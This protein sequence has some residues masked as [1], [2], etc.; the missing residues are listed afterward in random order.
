MLFDAFPVGQGRKYLLAVLVDIGDSIHSLVGVL[1]VDLQGRHEGGAVGVGAEVVA[2]GGGHLG[3]DVVDV[4]IVCLHGR[5]LVMVLVVLVVVGDG[6]VVDGTVT[7]C[8]KG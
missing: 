4:G 8:Q 5:R 1:L 3:E 7:P 6:A 2:D